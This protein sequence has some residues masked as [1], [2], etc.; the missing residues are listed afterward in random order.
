[1]LGCGLRTDWVSIALFQPRTTQQEQ[2]QTLLH[3]YINQFHNPSRPVRS[4]LTNNPHKTT[5]SFNPH[6]STRTLLTPTH[7]PITKF[8]STP[9]L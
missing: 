8:L 6:N 5:R 3:Q 7:I 4:T 2:H 1:M 9:T